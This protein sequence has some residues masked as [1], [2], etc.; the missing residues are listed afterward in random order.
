VVRRCLILLAGNLELISYRTTTFLGA[1]NEENVNRKILIAIAI[2]LLVAVALW[3]LSRTMS[4]PKRVQKCFDLGFKI[5]EDTP[6]DAIRDA[7]LEKIPVESSAKEIRNFLAESSFGSDSRNFMKTE[8]EG[9]SDTYQ[10]VCIFSGSGFLEFVFR[11]YVVTFDVDKTTE[12]L[13]DV[14]VNYGLTGL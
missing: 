10:I 8:E 6:N 9:E 2:V 4:S 12:T 5:T 11:E 1:I 13:S 7:I 3:G 14:R